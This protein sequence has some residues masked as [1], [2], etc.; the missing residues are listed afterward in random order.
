VRLVEAY[1][2]SRLVKAAFWAAILFA[3]VMAL[4]PH[5][6]EVHV[7]DFDKV[8]HG[9]AFAVLGVLGS[10]AYPRLSPLRLVIGLSLYGALI[11]ILQGTAFIHRDRDP[12][13]WVTDTVACAV[14][15]YL[16]HRLGMR[17]R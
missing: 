8:E 13:D 12:L 11:E 4:I 3:L 14:V 1:A 15:I 7:T 5:P 17:R 2:G 6:P 16:V 9:T 10:V